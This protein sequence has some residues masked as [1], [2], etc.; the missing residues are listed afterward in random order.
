MTKL[1]LQ[2]SLTESEMTMLAAALAGLLVCL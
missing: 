2:K 1:L